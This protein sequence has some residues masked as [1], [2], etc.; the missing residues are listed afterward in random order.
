MPLSRLDNFLKNVRGNT[1][2][3]NPQDLDATDDTTN[4]GN[5]MGKPFVTIQRALLEASR[6][7]YQK[8]LDN[9]RFSKTTIVLGAG[10][11][12]VDNRPGFIPNGTNNFILRSS[13]TT[14]DLA[15]LSNTSDFD[16]DSADNILYKINSIYGGVIVPRGTSIIADDVK[17]TRI[18][19]F[20]VPDPENSN[21]ERSAIFRLTG[22][23]YISD[24]TILDGSV[25]STV[26]KNYTTDRFVPNFSHHK[27]TVFEYADGVNSTRIDDEFQTFFTE[28][29]DLDMYY[30]KVGLLYGNLSGRPVF[31]NYPSD[32]VDIQ[33]RIDEFRIVGPISGEVGVSSIKAGDGATPTVT[34]T[35]NLEEGISGLETDTNF[36][37]SGVSDSDY[38]GSFSVFN[39]L[40]QNASNQTTSFTY[41]VNVV[42]SAAL[43]AVSGATIV[44]DSDTIEGSEP[45]INNVTVK[46][47]YGMCGAHADGDKVTGFKSM[48]FNHF[49]GIGLQ[50]D[51]NAFVKFNETTGGFDDSTSVDNIHSDSNAKYKPEY[52]NYHIKASNNASCEITTNFS[53]G[54][55]R[56]YVTETGGEFSVNGSISNFG[57]SALSASGFRDTTF[58]KDDIGY[59]T[60]IIPPT[61]ISPQELNIEYGSIDVAQTI[62]IG[63]TSRLYL[64]QEANQDSPPPTVLQGYRIGAKTNDRL[65]ANIT[66]NGVPILNYAR[67]IM[68]DTSSDSNQV[69]SVK[70]KTVGRNIGT[71]NSITS[72]TLTFTETHQLINGEAI[73]VISDNGRLPDGLQSNII[74]FA[75]TSGVNAN[76]IKIAATP[77]D[78]AN[79]IP[80]DINNLGGNLLIES[81]VSDKVAGDIGHPVQYD[82]SVNQWYV[83]VATASTDNTL[84][85]TITSLGV[86]GIGDAT[87][88]S[89][90]TRQP[91]QRGLNDTIY[92]M[93][94]VIPSGSGITSA[95]PP[96]ETFVVQSSSD[97][98]GAD[99]TEVAL[100]FNPGSV[101]MSNENEMRNFSFIRQADWNNGTALFTTELPHLVSIGSKVKITNVTSTNNTTGVAGSAYNG[102]FTVT[103]IN[104]ANQFKVNGT[105]YDPGYFTNDTSQRI[106]S[107]P[108]FQKIEGT[109]NL[110]IYNV[111][112]ISEYVTG[113]Q[114]GVYYLTGLTADKSPQVSPFNNSSDFAFSQPVEDLYPQYDR[115]NPVVD[116]D[117]TTSYALPLPL[118][119]VVVD[120]V[121]KSVTKES[122][123]N[124]LGSGGVGIGITDIVSDPTGIAHTIHT[125]YDHGLSRVTS[126]TI[127][128]AGSN[129]GNG[130]GSI[131]NLYNATL[132][133]SATG[134]NATARITVSAAGAITGVEIM[135]GGTGYIVG[136][137]LSVTGVAVTTGI[138]TGTVTVSS[139]YNN[140]N[141]SL[142][143]AGI[144]SI[145]YKGY[146]N[147]YKVTGISSTNRIE[148]N[149][150]SAVDGRSTTGVGSVFTSDAYGFKSGIVRSVSSIVFNNNVGLATIT[151]T[152]PHGYRVG[153]VVTL[154]GANESF[155]NNQFAITEN[156]GLTTFVVNTGVSTVSPA[157]GGTIE[158]Y[159]SLLGPSNGGVGNY[160]E[161]FGGRALDIYAGITTS[162]NVDVIN[163]TT[164][165]IEIVNIT[166]LDLNIGDYLRI[167][168]EIMRIKTTVTG[169]PVSVFRGLFGTQSTSH[170][171][172]SVV[173]KI[174][175]SPIELRKPSVIKASGHTFE[176]IG[177]GPGNYS[178]ALPD[179]QDAQPSQREQLLSQS[180]RA[181]G[182]QNVYVGM[183]DIGDYYIGNKKIS[184]STGKETVFDTP[185]PTIT[186]EDPTSINAQQQIT[187]VDATEVNVS[188]SLIVEGGPNSDIISEFNGPVLL[189]Q[190]VT[191]TSDDGIEANN[192]FLQGDTNISRKYTVS[193]N[194]PTLAGNPG[195]VVYKANP[196]AGGELGWTYTI[197]NGWYAVGGVSY[198]QEIDLQLVDRIGIATDSIESTGVPATFQVGSGTTL[199]H[200]GPDGKVG[201]GTTANE[202]GLRVSNGNILG[203]FVGD[204]SGLFNISNDSL[205]KETT[206]KDAIYPIDSRSVGIK[207][208]NPDVTWGLHVGTNGAGTQDLLVENLARF[209]GSVDINSDINIS[210]TLNVNNFN[211]NGSVSGII[212]SNA[213]DT[214]QLTVDTNVLTA[215]T[216]V[217]VGTVTSRAGLD[218][219]TDMRLVSY[220]EQSVVLSSTSGVVTIDLSSGT[221]FVLTPTEEI[222]RFVITSVPGNTASSSTF[223]LQIVQ[224]ST[225]RTV[226]INDFRNSG[227]VT[228]PLNWNGNVLPTVT[229]VANAEDVYSFFTFTGGSEYYGVVAGQNFGNSGSSPSTNN[230]LSYNASTA[231]VGVSSNLSVD[232]NG[233]FGGNVTAT[234]ITATGGIT[235][236]GD[237]TSG[238]DI[239]LKNNI[240]VVEGSLNILND[241][242]GISF[243]WN[244]NDKKSIGV[245]AQEVEKVLPELIG[246]TND[247]M[248]TVN[249]NGLVGVLIEA[250][251]EL[252]RRV[253]ELENK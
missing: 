205:W 18:R 118:G 228:I 47:T 174:K 181:N 31:P 24:F 172:D 213:V 61:S 72:N 134:A 168:D 110:Y 44:L 104:S 112:Q 39:V 176:F 101:T 76:Q 51:N 153:N 252:S 170:V 49:T 109:S 111:D 192:I 27:L 187:K 98:T 131:E 21:I 92:R 5:S 240:Q 97:V 178:T 106:T 13:A 93:R 122:Q 88:R 107:L 180:F 42:P 209:N 241:I 201:I 144:S 229:N 84:Y 141:D 161:R 155:W 22:G 6:F 191:S 59:I 190:K 50:V 58:D 17:K 185:I 37:I 52:Y 119:E 11:H 127:T 233:T 40:T 43:P 117:P 184:S 29:T 158:V 154:G 102:E 167:D 8:G 212:T 20:Y 200:I 46:S 100:Q 54:Y 173:K 244:S 32:G 171:E 103:G 128:S 238:S 68:D 105:T 34:I 99:N 222:T 196:E 90:I 179:R 65:T 239:R 253:E 145:R 82:T 85:P 217:G 28:R 14:A 60:N 87:P 3:V 208:V 16:L 70:V 194:K 197:D 220:Y 203:T 35:V 1:I 45:H 163:S 124:V 81:R 204:G 95:R 115:D 235:A 48:L 120:D 57:Q 125:L 243:N 195:D 198:D 165:E 225:P 156:V 91:T 129:Y 177:Y 138:T 116:P 160:D 186:G 2:Y 175:I 199:F 249:Y 219:N 143:V 193:I 121:R 56:Q 80:V 123:I 211:F 215:N 135:S 55:S 218:V 73:R 79:S 23:C 147:L 136:D 246:S 114:D 247:D 227:G 64:Y 151:T 169:N 63:Q 214:N 183:N 71:G 237:I 108:T 221:T 113:E 164:D 236:T 130:T 202:A 207:N 83:N 162:L 251:K 189:T 10:D 250:V 182:G 74:Y 62:S 94:Y 33:P 230:G 126:V 9:D 66:Q 232:I 25:N 234:N 149:S 12:Y 4:T 15:E 139:T 86:A 78:A 248:K 223:T 67:I 19:P 216:G 38:N 7:S 137:V 140:V 96:R 231:T 36:E 148:V 206:N 159:T 157:T 224:G 146:N 41:K 152:K 166:N 132:V 53:I 75:I 30:E 150:I 188:R 245:V 133:G 69:T 226:D 142:T 77:N 26:Y 242:R 89:F 210:G